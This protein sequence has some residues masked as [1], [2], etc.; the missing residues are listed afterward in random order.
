MFSACLLVLPTLW[1]VRTDIALYGGD[2]PHLQ[3]RLTSRAITIAGSLLAMWPGS[4]W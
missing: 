3:Q 2:W 4:S 1:Y